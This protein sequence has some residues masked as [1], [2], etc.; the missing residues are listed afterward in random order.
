MKIIL[1]K[2]VLRVKITDEINHKSNIIRI[3]THKISNI[4][5]KF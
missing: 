3:L 4:I 2:N 1:K 5:I